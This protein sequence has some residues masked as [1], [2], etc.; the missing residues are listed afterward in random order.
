MLANLV[1]QNSENAES[2]LNIQKMLRIMVEIRVDIK[3]H[4]KRNN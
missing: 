3:P 2:L 4:F 1:G